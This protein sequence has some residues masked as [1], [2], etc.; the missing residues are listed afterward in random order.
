MDA[1][2]LDFDQYQTCAV[3]TLKP[4][5]FQRTVLHCILGMVGEAGEL[6]QLASHQNEQKVGELGD[7]MWYA[8][9]L[10]HT[11]GIKFQSLF[12]KS[13]LLRPDRSTAEMQL[14]IQGCAM[15]DTIKKSV[16]YGKDLDQ[17]KLEDML[18]RYVTGLYRV[19][20]TLRVPP[21]Y[22]AKTNVE[23]LEARYGGVF[24]A[25]KAI[26]RDHAAESAAAGIQTV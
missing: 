2:L 16:F 15:A 9:C 21:L 3:K 19:C 17:P 26:N 5:D 13:M 7:C 4:D 8:A 14:L 12:D 6:I 20:W 25:D 23:K 10:A 22:V 1:Q 11:L 18:C 24:S